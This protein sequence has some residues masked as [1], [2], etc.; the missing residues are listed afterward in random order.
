MVLL[1]FEIFLFCPN[2]SFWL[3][4]QFKFLSLIR[5][6]SWVIFLQFWFCQMLCLGG[7]FFIFMFLFY[8]TIWVF[9]LS[10]L[11]YQV[12]SQFEFLNF[13]LIS[14]FE[15]LCLV[16]IWIFLSFTIMFF[17]ILFYII[18]IFLGQIICHDNFIFIIKR[19]VH[20]L[21]ITNKFYNKSLP[22]QFVLVIF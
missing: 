14:A 21:C 17:I 2:F 22:L 20:N 16:T 9:E 1:K 15:F 18:T 5:F 4:S 3:I 6:F 7:F 11:E 10:P 19:V 8:V 12:L 13:V